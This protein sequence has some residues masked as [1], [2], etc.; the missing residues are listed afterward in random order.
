MILHVPDLAWLGCESLS[1]IILADFLAAG[2]TQ[3]PATGNM[4]SHVP[5][6]QPGTTETA[7]A[8]APFV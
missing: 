8:S 6:R 3:I 4:V 2:V 7:P 1:W 5:V